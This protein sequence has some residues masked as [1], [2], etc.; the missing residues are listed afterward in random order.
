[1]LAH[2]NLGVALAA[3]GDKDRAMTALKKACDLGLA[4]RLTLQEFRAIGAPIDALKGR[5]DFDA[6]V[7]S[8]WPRAAQK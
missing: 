3:S 1:V 4:R 7:K 6:M 2:A 8:A 5:P